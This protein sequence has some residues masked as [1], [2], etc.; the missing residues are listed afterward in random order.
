MGNEVL[1]RLNEAETLKILVTLDDEGV[2]HPTVKSSLRS[3][4]AD[5]LYSE[6]LESSRTNRYMTRSLWF[7]RNVSIL[8]VTADQKSYTITA[9][10]VRAIISGKIFQ[11][12]YEETLE[13]TGLDLA[14]VWILKP[15]NI[16]NETLSERVAE[17]AEKRPYFVH[18]DRLAKNTEEVL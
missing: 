5:I 17:E 2:P 8:I 4:G 12:Y 9:R 10:P 3:D 16:I 15:L 11:R 14:S 6:Y 1:G 18:L 13:K 7:N